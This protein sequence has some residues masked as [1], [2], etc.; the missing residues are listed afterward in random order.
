MME[1]DSTITVSM[2]GVEY[3]NDYDHEDD[4]KMTSLLVFE[5]QEFAWPPSNKISIF[6]ANNNSKSECG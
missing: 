1:G 5:P 3:R 2:T 6:G 4:K